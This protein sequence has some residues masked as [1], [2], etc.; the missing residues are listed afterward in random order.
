[1]YLLSS[2]G[3][4]A[5]PYVVASVPSAQKCTLSLENGAAVQSGEEIAMA[6][7]EAA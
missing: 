4:R 7:L 3:S 5:G 6:K 1:M 2:D